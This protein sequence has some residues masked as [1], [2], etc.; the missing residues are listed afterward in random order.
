VEAPAQPYTFHSVAPCSHS[1]A[2]RTLRFAAA[3]DSSDG[4]ER[5]HDEPRRWT[6]KQLRA[7]VRTHAV[8]DA[9]L[10]EKHEFVTAVRAVL[11]THPQ[12]APS[13]AAAVS[14]DVPVPRGGS[15][16]TST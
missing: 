13:P 6:L 2:T 12:L 9:G 8:P 10:Y 5:Q 1:A 16:D 14:V 11:E 3:S 15:F 4:D 7:F